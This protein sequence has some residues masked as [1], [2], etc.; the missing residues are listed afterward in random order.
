MIIKVVIVVVMVVVVVVIVVIV[1]VVV[2]VV[3]VVILKI[4]D[5][6]GHHELKENFFCFLGK[7]NKPQIYKYVF[8]NQWKL[9]FFK[10]N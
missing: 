1:K 3:V 6:N 8:E 9:N 10:K 4:I 5:F 2:V 7:S